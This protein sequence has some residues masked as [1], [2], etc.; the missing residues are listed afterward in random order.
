[1]GVGDELVAAGRTSTR[2]EL[3][4]GARMVAV[5]LGDIGARDTRFPFILSPRWQ[6]ITSKW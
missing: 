4:F 5:T 1:M 2:L 6:R 3:H